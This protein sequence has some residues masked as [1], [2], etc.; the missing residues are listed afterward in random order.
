MK[1][2]GFT[3][4]ELLAVLVILV[5]I[6]LIAVPIIF[7]IVENSR[8][9]GAERG[10]EN[11]ISAVN[12]AVA[13]QKLKDKK[14]KPNSCE[15][16]EAGKLLCDDGSELVVEVKGTIPESG[17]IYLTANT[18]TNYRNIKLG[19]Y[20]ATKGKKGTAIT[21]EY[22]PICKA[23]TFA[24]ATKWSS[25]AN[26]TAGNVPTGKLQAGDEYICE[27]APGVEHRFY[28]LPDTYNDGKVRL[29][30]DRNITNSGEY[31]KSSYEKDVPIYR[32]NWITQEDYE[33][34][35]GTDWGN[36]KSAKGPLTALAYVR[37]ATQ[38]WVNIPDLNEPYTDRIYGT[39]QLTGK[40]RLPQYKEVYSSGCISLEK[41]CPLWLVNYTAPNSDK[42]RYPGKT[43][44]T[45][46]NDYWLM[47]S[48][49]WNASQGYGILSQGAAGGY[50]VNSNKG[51][52]PVITIEK[53]DI[54]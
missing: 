7:D 26:K 44:Y 32:V 2:K 40:A 8:I 45:L 47:D 28:V 10:L 50:A 23:V 12:N 35:G 24:T 20:Y 49:S 16:K 1:N 29:I 38:K 54:K 31:V 39:I 21:E 46:P 53:Q 42:G 52:R 43:P 22:E 9:K 3:L 30:L 51:I 27:V 13:A 18:V 11:Y 5:I 6:A 36:A 33:L 41:R 48:I 15:I 34:A 17:V 19:D 25:D 4:I 37:E 14:Y